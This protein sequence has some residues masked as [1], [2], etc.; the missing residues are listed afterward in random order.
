[1]VKTLSIVG[2]VYFSV[3]AAASHNFTKYHVA[4]D[5]DR[6]AEF[7][8]NAT[9][10]TFWPSLAATIA[11]LVVG[12]PMLW[13]FGSEYVGGYH[14]MFILAI[15]TI[16]RASIGPGGRLLNMLGELRASA[17]AVIGAFAI[18]LLLCLMLIPP[19]GATGAAIATTTAFIVESVLLFIVTKRRVGLHIFI[20]RGAK[21]RR[22]T[23]APAAGG[24]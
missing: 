18:N 21:A 19:F 1:M 17:L 11:I 6:L 14:L 12:W 23:P 10:W 3:S 16:A 20:W 5:R 22:A 8:A 4:G 15:G 7:A 2:F 13:L 9:R 24:G